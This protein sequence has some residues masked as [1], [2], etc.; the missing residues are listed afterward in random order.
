MIRCEDLLEQAN[1]YHSEMM[2][3]EKQR[4]LFKEAFKQIKKEKH[5]IMLK[6]DKIKKHKE[7]LKVNMYNLSLKLSVGPKIV[8][9]KI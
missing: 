9:I 2:T 3:L 4:D 8:N 6:C 7:M 1:A 5:S